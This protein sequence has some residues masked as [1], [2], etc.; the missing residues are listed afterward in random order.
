MLVPVVVGL[1]HSPSEATNKA[2]VERTSAEWLVW[3]TTRRGWLFALV[4][5][6]PEGGCMWTIEWEY[7]HVALPCQPGE[8]VPQ[9]SLTFG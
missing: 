3:G 7:V 4:S 9:Q 2:K 6:T 5:V 1:L 8:L